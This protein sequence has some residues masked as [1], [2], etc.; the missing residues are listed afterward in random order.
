MITNNQIIFDHFNL[1]LMYYNLVG[2]VLALNLDQLNKTNGY[3]NLYWGWG[4]S[5]QPKILNCF[6]SF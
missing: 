2:G 5:F 4:I 6:E 3:S 1:S